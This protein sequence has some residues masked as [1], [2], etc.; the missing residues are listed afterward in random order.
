MAIT[1]AQSD[2]STVAC[3]D[4]LGL[5]AQL[6]QHAEAEDLRSF[7]L[8]VLGDL[9]QYDREHHGE[10]LQTL[11]QFFAQKGNVLATAREMRISAGSIK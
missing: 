10:L 2:D 9:V 4:Q 5:L 1:R 7:A 11:Y 6:T 8:S 3:F